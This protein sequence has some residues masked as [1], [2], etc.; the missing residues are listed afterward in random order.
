MDLAFQFKVIL[1]TSRHARS[2]DSVVGIPS[3]MATILQSLKS[4]FPT[5]TSYRS[6]FLVIPLIVACNKEATL[7]ISGM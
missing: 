3:F 4:A 7:L 5:S 2:N 1:P 6:K